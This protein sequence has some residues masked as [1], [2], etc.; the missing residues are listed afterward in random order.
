MTAI[1]ATNV[2]LSSINNAHFAQ[3][4]RRRHAIKCLTR[5]PL[6][7]ISNVIL[8][9]NVWQHLAYSTHISDGSCTLP[10]KHHSCPW[11]IQEWFDYDAIR[12][13]FQ[14]A[15]TYVQCHLLVVILY[16]AVWQSLTDLL[17][18]S[19]GCYRWCMHLP[20]SSR[21]ATPSLF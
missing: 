7:D 4:M 17:R 5:L 9:A 13:I 19:R 20:S 15:K 6:S 2:L 8:R 10:V 14:C 21:N 16:V 18:H 1:S 3:F 12:R 11:F